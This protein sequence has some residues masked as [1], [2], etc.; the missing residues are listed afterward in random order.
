MTMH[1]LLF[2]AHMVKLRSRH[3][4]IRVS[5]S[6]ANHD[7]LCSFLHGQGQKSEKKKHSTKN[8]TKVQNNTSIKLCCKVRTL[9]IWAN[10][11]E[12]LTSSFKDLKERSPS[13]TTRRLKE[14]NHGIAVESTVRKKMATGTF[15]HSS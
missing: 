10:C 8:I 15:T 4:S 7:L 14:R 3:V 9:N 12:T 2:C 1:N 5:S 6:R 11:S 13:S